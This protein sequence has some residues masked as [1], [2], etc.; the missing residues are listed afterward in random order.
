VALF[1]SKITWLNDGLD[2]SPG[3]S[4][5]VVDTIS[6]DETPAPLSLVLNWTSELKK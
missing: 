3:E 4:R 5:F 6:T 1:Q 2:V